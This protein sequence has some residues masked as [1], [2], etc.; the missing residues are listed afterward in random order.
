MKTI[1]LFV[2]LV[3]SVFVGIGQNPVVKRYKTGEI[4]SRETPETWSGREDIRQE[5]VE[6]FNRKGQKV[7][8]GYR[9][10][11]AGHSYIDLTYHEN[12]GVKKIETSSAPDAG[13]QWYRSKYVLDE[14]G[15]VIDFQKQSHESLMHVTLPEPYQLPPQDEPEQLVKKEPLKEVEPVK[16]NPVK[17][18]LVKEEPPKETPIQEVTPCCPV[19]MVTQ[20]VIYNRT[21]KALEITLEHRTVNSGVN[22]TVNVAPKDSIQTGNTAYAQHF[23]DPTVVYELKVKRNKKG[24]PEVVKLA[25]LPVR[26]YQRDP[27]HKVFQYFILD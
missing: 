13:I 21:K 2:F 20:I 18:E 11:F 12:G 24:E 3:S 7:Y 25:D 17:E 23:I 22:F 15:N 4:A 27:Q 1:L 26:V 6:V 8:E 14:D 10:N 9:R 19:P 5:K 16:E